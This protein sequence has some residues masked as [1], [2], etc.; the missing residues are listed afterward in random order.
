MTFTRKSNSHCE[1]L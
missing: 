1:V